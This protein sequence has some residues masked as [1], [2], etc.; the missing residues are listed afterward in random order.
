[1][2]TNTGEAVTFLVSE[3]YV[4]EFLRLLE[5]ADVVSVDTET[6]GVYPFN[7]D[8]L[9][10]V[11]AGAN[12]TYGYLPFRHATGPNL[13]PER[14]SQLV[15][16]LSTKTLRG[17]HLRFDIEML[18][19]EGMALPPKIEDALLAALLVNENEPCFALKRGKRGDLGLAPRY[20]GEDTV[21]ESDALDVVLRSRGLP[22]A[23]I[24]K[25]RPEE[26]A[27]YTCADL[28]LPERL[29]R[30]VYRPALDTWGMSDVFEEYNRYQLMLIEMEIRGIPIDRGVVTEA[31]VRGREEQD[32][33]LALIHKSA[34]YELNPASWKQVA[35]W[36]GTENAQEETILASKHPSA[37]FLID[38]KAYTKRDSTYLRRFLEYADEC[39]HLHPQLN[40]TIDERDEGGTKSGR[41]SSSHPNFTAIPKPTTNPL[42]SPCRRAV[43]AP[44]GYCI[45]KADYQQAEAWIAGHY[46]NDPAILEAYHEGR[47]MYA[48]LAADIRRD[49]QTCKTLHLAIQ[50]G[51]G[52]WKVAQ[53]LGV[54]EGIA[55]ELRSAWHKRFPR[56]SQTMSR[57]NKAAERRGAIRLFTGRWCHFDGDKKSVVC[58]SP[59]YTAWNRL[60]Q[61]SVAEMIRRAMLQLKPRLELLSSRIFLQVHDELLMFVPFSELSA[62]TK[63]VRET[64]TDFPNW[65]LRPRI[66]LSAGL[67]WLEMEAIDDSQRTLG[68]LAPPS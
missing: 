67:N 10:G 61:G 25:L 44:P 24:Y 66:D 55:R 16:V 15:K 32:A 68:L 19:N 36:L 22:K 62:A 9:V 4:P 56:I 35:L 53:T 13:S 2:G 39:G 40:L 31:L 3:G 59:Y 48:E 7:G 57:V 43:V 60:I 63:V 41:I 54:S 12:G 29:L 37:R 20:L 58:K 47:D 49:R 50:Y 52:A 34:G 1:M 18:C 11:A 28:T 5:S 21:A 45:L 27:A 33:L 23:E 42:Y 64:M 46:S 6:T 65:S 26:V 30:D 51:A 38:Y 8:R 17:F 14:L